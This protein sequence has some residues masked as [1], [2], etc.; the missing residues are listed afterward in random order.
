VFCPNVISL[1]P[2]LWTTLDESARTAS[3]LPGATLIEPFAGSG[4]IVSMLKCE[5]LASDVAAFDLCPAADWIEA[6]DC[7]A[8][9]PTTPGVVV[10]NPPYIARNSARRR[11]LSF[12]QTSFADA[13]LHALDLMLNAS[14]YVA[15]IIP[16][17]FGTTTYFRDRM[18]HIVE[19]P[20]DDMFV[21]TDHPVSL[22]MFEPVSHGAMVWSWERCLG[23]ERSL[24]RAIPA[25][26]A[27]AKIRF[28]V[29]S[30][31]IGL[32]AVDA[33]L[34]PTIS[35]V[36]GEAIAHG[37]VKKSSRSVTRLDVSGVTRGNRDEF[38]DI[39]NRR[40]ERIR[41]MTSDAVL[42]PFKGLRR[43]GSF[44]RRLD[45]RT[46]RIVLSMALDEMNSA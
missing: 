19:L 17:A 34:G 16:A 24:W 45:Y 21:D 26:P 20:F 39:V 10:T 37:Q 38:I 15:A 31:L 35:F 12:P 23:S 33:T 18:T 9:Y 4:S 40:L 43:D 30:G 41:A 25:L 11:G 3:I 32:R 44:R 13:Y 42:T 7:F 29:P 6:R 14:P 5:G 46:A 27:R 1:F 28:N 8:N 22:A 2:Y 36:R